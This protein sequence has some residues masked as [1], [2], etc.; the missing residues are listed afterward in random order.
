[1]RNTSGHAFRAAAS[2]FSSHQ[3][4]AYPRHVHPRQTKIFQLSQYAKTAQ[5]NAKLTKLENIK[6]E[7]I[8]KKLDTVVSVS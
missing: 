8:S 3:P 7:I 1:M 6:T 2:N 4:P 5:D